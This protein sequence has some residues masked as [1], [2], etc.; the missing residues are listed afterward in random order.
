MV[1]VR[2]TFSATMNCYWQTVKKVFREFAI[3]CIAGGVGSGTVHML[4]F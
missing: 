2:N 3:E 4:V 1:A